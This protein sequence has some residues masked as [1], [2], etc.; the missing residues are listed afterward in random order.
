[1]DS[2]RVGW[3]DCFWDAGE[4]LELWMDFPRVSRL[5]EELLEDRKKKM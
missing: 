3:K 4:R 2:V 1:M 5:E